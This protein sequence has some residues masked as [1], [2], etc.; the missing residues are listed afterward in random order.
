M[1]TKE[2]CGCQRD[3]LAIF[4]V[5]YTVIPT[6]LNCSK[7]SWAHLDGVTTVPL[8]DDYQYHIRRIR[9]GFIYLHL[10][11]LVQNS[12]DEVN[13]ADIDKSWIVYEVNSKGQ[14][15]LQHSIF[16]APTAEH[17]NDDSYKCP[18]LDQNPELTSFITI[19]N[20]FR[21]EKAYIAYSEFPWT[22][23]MLLDSTKSP[24]PRM[25]EINIQ[26][27]KN[28]QQQVSATVATEESLKQIL[29]FDFNFITDR[30]MPD[31]Q[32][33]NE[34]YPMFLNDDDKDRKNKAIFWKEVTEKRV[35]KVSD[36]SYTG[37]SY[38]TEYFIEYTFKK[39]KLKLN[40]TNQP[41]APFKTK[42]FM[43]APGTDT[44][45]IL[46]EQYQSSLHTLYK[47][48]QNYSG[49]DGTPMILAIEDALGVAQDLNNYYNDIYGHLAQFKKEAEMECDVK[50]C[51]TK[52]RAYVESDVAKKDFEIAPYKDEIYQI[53]DKGLTIDDHDYQKEK[54]RGLVL[55]KIPAIQLEQYG[56]DINIET[57][58]QGLGIDISVVKNSPAPRKR[59][60]YNMVKSYILLV[61]DYFYGKP[62]GHLYYQKFMNYLKFDS[63]EDDKY[64]MTHK[65]NPGVPGLAGYYPNS[66]YA[67]LVKYSSFTLDASLIETKETALILHKVYQELVNDYDSKKEQHKAKLDQKVDKALEKYTERLDSKDFDAILNQVNKEVEKI[68]NERA[69]QLIRWLE[70]SHYLMAI[71]DLAYEDNIKIDSDDPKWL[72]FKIEMDKELKE[73]LSNE[74]IT[75]EQCEQL[76]NVNINGFYFQS[77]YTRSTHG[78]EGCETGRQFN[79]KMYDLKHLKGIDV[80]SGAY[81]KLRKTHFVILALRAQFFDFKPAMKVL[82]NIY[83]VVSNE[84][85]TEYKEQLLKNIEIESLSFIT[86]QFRYAT[87]M[88]E[89][90]TEL[91]RLKK[92]E[93]LTTIALNTNLGKRTILIKYLANYDSPGLIC[94]GV[95]RMHDNLIKLCKPIGNGLYS[96]GAM[97]AES[98]ILALSGTVWKICVVYAH[99]KYQL[100]EAWIT[101]KSL[102]FSGVDVGGGL[103]LV[104]NAYSAEVK[105]LIKDLRNSLN[106]V[107][108]DIDQRFH[109]QLVEIEHVFKKALNI[110]FKVFEDGTG[111]NV[112]RKQLQ[113]RSVRLSF[114]VGA[115]EIYNWQYVMDKKPNLFANDSDIIMEKMIATS[116]LIAAAADI[117]ASVTK[118]LTG[119]TSVF[120]YSKFT[121]GVFTGLVSFLMG[122]KMIKS[123]IQDGEFGSVLSIFLASASSLSYFASGSAFSLMCMSYRYAWVQTFIEA[124][125]TPAAEKLAARFAKKGVQKAFDLFAMRTILFRFAGVVGI[126]ALVLELLYDY[127]SDDEIQVW[128]TYSAL[129]VRKGELRFRMSLDQINS[130][131][132]LNMFVEKF[133]EESGVNL[134]QINKKAIESMK[135]DYESILLTAQNNVHKW[136]K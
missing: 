101:F 26:A 127:F 75:E 131:K 53:I 86:S 73:A 20:S 48:M 112:N 54:L 80:E 115:F 39:E 89:Y 111:I 121:F 13:L 60:F 29:D 109:R 6:Y 37:I 50:Q 31:N 19:P 128:I 69:K 102:S 68:A 8:N 64:H 1:N 87:L 51:M 132:K 17:S 49:N 136:L 134:S 42:S 98:S 123:I 35:S 38:T 2:K 129:G 118:V 77:V 10:P 106:Q 16:T 24:L 81:I 45:A 52:V 70:Q 58:A 11:S 33:G 90:F 85:E 59:E 122:A 108:K 96:L 92:I 3:G 55:R 61:K 63:Y 5:R 99:L 32:R 114:L 94:N 95:L 78:L 76:K 117:T 84:Q 113:F 124:K 36:V 22:K 25:Q 74:E 130:F 67:K 110:T 72:E 7:P 66:I 34:I 100:F 91:Q 27:W 125:I 105:K 40:S 135:N 126:I 56:G 83:D 21:H 62:F 79:Q 107:I 23:E 119:R 104:S 97:I 44:K 46:A 71:N 133:Q 41:W 9:E 82:Q 57:V 30:L 15:T 4:P 18:N 47:N 88:L 93:G 120:I 65:N 103:K 12:L 14:L 116:S 28:Q 43:T